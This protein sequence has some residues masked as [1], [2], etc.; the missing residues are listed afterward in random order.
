[1]DL[2]STFNSTAFNHDIGAWNVARVTSLIGTF[3]SAK[4]FNQNIGSWNVA[5]VT[6]RSACSHRAARVFGLECKR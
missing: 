3:D 6:V 2:E 5:R 4:A 1:M